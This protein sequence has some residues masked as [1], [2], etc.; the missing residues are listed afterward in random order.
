MI[1]MDHVS[2]L[3]AA[4][5]GDAMTPAE[6]ATMRRRL[7]RDYAVCALREKVRPA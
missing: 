3:I 2:R 5:C 1:D 4:R 6:I 7:N